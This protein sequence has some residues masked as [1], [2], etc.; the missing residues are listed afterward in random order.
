MS[1]L[2]FKRHSHRWARGLP[3]VN[4]C[5][6]I[7]EIHDELVRLGAEGHR[8]NYIVDTQEDPQVGPRTVIIL[9]EVNATIGK[10]KRFWAAVRTKDDPKESPALDALR[11]ILF[12]GRAVQ[13]HVLAVAQSATVHALGGPEMRECFATRILARYTVNAWKMLVPEV[14][15]VPRSTRHIGRAQVVL[16]GY[17]IETQVLFFSDAEAREWASTGIVA[18]P[19]EVSRHASH[20]ALTWENEADTSCDVTRKLTLVKPLA[21]RMSLAEAARREII[22][23]KADALRQAKRRDPEF[24]QGVDGKYTAEELVRWHRN[25]PVKTA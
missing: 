21:E 24:P 16:G 23:M 10:L 9:E 6:E 7:E 5:R 15:P 20:N 13:M 25:R 17:A 14:H 19:P 12:M 8:R 22:P 1:V 2:D 11:E 18:P 4:Y 3:Q